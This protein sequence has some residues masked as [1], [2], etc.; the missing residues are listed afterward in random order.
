MKIFY[1]DSVHC[2]CD[3]KRT[4]DSIKP[5]LEY[6]AEAWQKTQYRKVG[7]T[8]MKCVVADERKL[9][10]YTGHLPVIKKYA[11]RK[12][13]PLVIKGAPK[14]NSIES[15]FCI[16]NYQYNNYEKDFGETP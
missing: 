8:Y 16:H 4:L 11:K 2:K 1:L 9:L 15:M 7:R 14:K 3:S 13:L 5:C 10:V 12:K 6:K